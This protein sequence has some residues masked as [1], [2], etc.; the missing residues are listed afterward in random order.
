MLKDGSSN[1][2]IAA[3][4]QVGVE[5]VRTHARNIYRKLGVTSRLELSQ[6]P[7]RPSAPGWP[8]PLSI[9]HARGLPASATGSAAAAPRLAEDQ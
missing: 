9:R 6:A 3:A 8:A 7:P 1:A 2:E 5:T 4:L